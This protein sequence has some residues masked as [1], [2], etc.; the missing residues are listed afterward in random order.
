MGVPRARWTP[1]EVTV[2]EGVPGG[3]AIGVRVRSGGPLVMMNGNIST[4]EVTGGGVEGLGEG[5]IP[6][7]GDGEVG[8]GICAGSGCCASG[9]PSGS[10]SGASIGSGSGEATFD[11]RSCSST[12]DFLGRVAVGKSS[13]FDPGEGTIYVSEAITGVPGSGSAERF[14]GLALIED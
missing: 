7:I 8:S 5:G 1:I 11:P 2:E 12:K 13:P 6:F 4:G 9:L 3:W 10:G 14:D